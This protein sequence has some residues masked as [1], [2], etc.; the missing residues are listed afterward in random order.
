MAR[1][2]AC[3][4]RLEGIVVLALATV[5]ARAPSA[6]VR[7]GYDQAPRQ[8]KRAAPGCDGCGGAL[9]RHSPLQDLS[10]GVPGPHTPAH[11]AP[12]GMLARHD[13]VLETGPDGC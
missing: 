13:R 9:A 6:R 12:A 7:Q 11:P 3:P 2:T 8:R 5:A 10:C 4:D 1:S